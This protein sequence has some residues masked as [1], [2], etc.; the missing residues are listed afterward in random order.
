MGWRW[1]TCGECF[2]KVFLLST[3][4]RYRQR[5]ACVAAQSPGP[6]GAGF[7]LCPLGRR[8]VALSRAAAALQGPLLLMWKSCRRL[9]AD[10]LFVGAA[11]LL[12]LTVFKWG[13]F[14]GRVEIVRAFGVGQFQVTS[15]L[16]KLHSV[17]KLALLLLICMLLFQI[18]L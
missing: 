11:S 6:A 14:K 12:A 8:R 3:L 2:C 17:V 9:C 7:G 10:S 15:L 18:M 13:L 16:T 4:A 5:G 1:C